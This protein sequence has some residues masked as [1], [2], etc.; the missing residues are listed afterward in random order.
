VAERLADILPDA[1]LHVYDEPNVLWTQRADLRRRIS[2]F[3]N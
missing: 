3:L 2:G 1:S